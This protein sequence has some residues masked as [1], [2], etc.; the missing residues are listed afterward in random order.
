M[1]TPV[2]D[3]IERYAKSGTSRFHMP[4]HKGKGPLGIEK[5]DITEID[6]ADVLSTAKG[7]IEESEKNLTALYGSGKSF[8]ITQGS[9]TAICAML[10]MIKKPEREKTYV[11]AARNVH[12]AFVHALALLDIEADWIM[13]KTANGVLSCDITAFDVE[14]TLSSSEGKYSAVYLTSPDYLGQ[15]G[16]IEEISKVCHKYNVPLLVDN[17]HGAYLKFL[18]GSMH[19]ID[20]GADICCDS[21]HKTLPV[22]TGG[23]YLHIT[24]RAEDFI[25]TARE[26]IALFSSTSP[27][28]LTMKSLDMCNLYIKR[29]FGRELS[30]C[31]AKIKEVKALI[32]KKGFVLLESEPLKIVINAAKSGYTGI[33]LAKMMRKA[34]M[35]A[36][37]SD[38]DYLVLMISPQNTTRDFRRLKKFFCEINAKSEIK[39]SFTHLPYPVRKISAREA[40]FA[41]SE[42]TET[43]LAKGKI[44]ASVTVSCPPAVPIVVS[45]EVITEEVIEALLYYGIDEIK[46]VSD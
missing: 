44:C 40:F 20:K 23:A 28:Y 30:D 36:E 14:A 3:F 11:L 34:K 25:G 10:S 39:R 1:K 31:I 29:N 24:K 7:I 5:Y 21:A 32:V 22:L 37:F 4:G 27:S 16:D 45:G 15:I 9:S 35:E 26:K 2:S 38:D 8:Y 41:K 17:A 13:T 19:P 6:G 42:V 12:K 33:E 43:R 18:K 46:T